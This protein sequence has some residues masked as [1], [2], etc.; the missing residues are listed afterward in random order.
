[1]VEAMIQLRQHQSGRTMVEASS[2]GRRYVRDG[3]SGPLTTGQ[4]EDQAISDSR[5]GYRAHNALSRLLH[6]V[7]RWE[8][9]FNDGVFPGVLVLSDACLVQCSGS[10][11]CQ[12]EARAR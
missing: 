11:Q 6:L 4:C 2:N 1:M 10:D 3:G 8:R 9:W 5:S 7:P 12:S